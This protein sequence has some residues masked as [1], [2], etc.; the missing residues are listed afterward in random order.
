MNLTKTNITDIRVVYKS[1]EF[2]MFYAG[3]SENVKKKFDYVLNVVQT[4]YN[5]PQKF[6]KKLE[7]TDFYEM[8]VS[9]GTNE[10][11]SV[12]FAIDHDNVIE[13]TKIILLNAFVKKSTKDY[14]KE[15]DKAEN[16]LNSLEL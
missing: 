13:S 4:V 9:I 8:R 11:R 5:I 6:I 7:N 2:E 1:E 10:Y 12:L 14:K 15:I 16:I 3:L